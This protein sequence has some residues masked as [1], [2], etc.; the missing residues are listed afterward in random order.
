MLTKPA[1]STFAILL[2]FL[3]ACTPRPTASVASAIAEVQARENSF[4]DYPRAGRTYLTFSAAH[5]FQVIYI[6]TN[7]RSWLWYPDNSRALPGRYR[8]DMVSGQEALCWQYS[9]NTYNPVTQT[10]GGSFQ[11]E[12]LL[13]AQ[14]SVISQML[15][16]VFQLTSTAVPYRLDRCTAPTEFAFDRDEFAC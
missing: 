6:G 2:M 12:P 13:F 10:Q 16:D 14:R 11:C 8:R 7:G 1:L 4:A 3:S 5:G 9:S 15:G